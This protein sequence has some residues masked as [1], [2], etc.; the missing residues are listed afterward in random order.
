MS[1]ENRFA[2]A[3][4]LTV[5]LSTHALLANQALISDDGREVLLKDDGSW[6][7]RSEDRF[8][9]TSDGRRVRLKEDGSWV[10]VGNAPLVTKEQARSTIV[11]LKMQKIEIESH[12][13]KVHKN[14]RT[15]RQT[16]FYINVDVSPLAKQSLRVADT[17]L[18]SI[19]V[20]DDKGNKY[21]VLSIKP[22]K[23]EVAPNSNQTFVIRA[24]DAPTIW[25]GAELMEIQLP[26]NILGNPEP[27]T[28][29]RKLYDIEQV[30][31]EGF[32]QE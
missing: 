18:D 2:T 10:Y 28:F 12:K 29:S 6:E 21:P 30:R 17:G 4:F 15:E 9:N 7:F 20:M 11:D 19:L 24:R 27:V 14:T 13:E 16:V 5:S 22:D 32:E 3:L 31:V 1:I 25:D 23:I 8:A 26:V